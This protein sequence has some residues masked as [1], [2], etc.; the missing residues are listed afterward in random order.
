MVGQEQRPI[1]AQS[2]LV[3]VFL[4]GE[5]GRAE[6][7]ADL[8]TLGGVDRH[9]RGGDL[10]V[11]LGVD[12]GAPAGGGAGRLDLD[13]GAGGRAGLA[14]GFQMGLPGLDHGRVRAPEGIAFDLIPVPAGAVDGMGPDLD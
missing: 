7:L 12:G 3:G 4:A 11:Q 5:G 9:E 1:V 2:H 6:A 14:D 13:N 10:G 8:H